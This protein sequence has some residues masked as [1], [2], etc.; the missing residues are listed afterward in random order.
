MPRKIHHIV[1]SNKDYLQ[2]RCYVQGGHKSAR[3]I[4]RAR[5]LLF[6]D[7]GMTDEDIASTLGISM[8]TVYRVRKNYNTSGL[9][10]ALAE[11]PRRGAPAKLDGRAE[12]TLTMLACSAPPAGYGRWT[13]QLLADKLVELQVVDAISLPTISTALKKTN[14]NRG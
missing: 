1:L 2:L 9:T 5:I 10:M 8:A 12:A 3:A 4:N 6:A 13:L 7:M 11:K 14:L